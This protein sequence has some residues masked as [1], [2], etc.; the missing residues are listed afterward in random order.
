MQ[1]LVLIVQ[2]F[3]ICF[4]SVVATKMADEGRFELAFVNAICVAINMFFVLMF[5]IENVYY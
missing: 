5:I 1:G 3:L 2:T 4:C